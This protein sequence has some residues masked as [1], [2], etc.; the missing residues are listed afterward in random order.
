[1]MTIFN[2]S[3]YEDVLVVRVH[4]LINEKTW[5]R[6]YDEINHFEAMLASS[7]TIILKFFLHITKDE[8]EKR[9]LAREQDVNK[10]WKLSEGDWRERRLWDKYVEAYED[11]LGK[12]STQVAPW[13]IV[14]ANKKWFRNLAVA[15]AIVHALRPYKKEW[16]DRLDEI[17][18]NARAELSAMRASEV[19]P[20]NNSTKSGGRQL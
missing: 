8:Q 10:G 11:A 4:D 12:T 3:H 7:N 15:E 14:P 19:R 5:K 9:L 18:K 6:R 2:R 20:K 1:M 13:H 17:S 16:E